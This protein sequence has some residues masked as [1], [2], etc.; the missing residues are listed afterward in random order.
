[1]RD[2]GLKRTASQEVPALLGWVVDWRVTA[3]LAMR[4]PGPEE[5]AAPEIRVLPMSGTD[6]LDWPWFAGGHLHD[7]LCDGLLWDY[8][9]SGQL[10][11][12]VPLLANH[13]GSV[14]WV[15]SPH[16]CNMAYIVVGGHLRAEEYWLPAG[17][18]VDQ[19]WLREG[20]PTPS[21]R[22]LLVLPGAMDLAQV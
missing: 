16:G 21:A 1:M 6:G 15:P 3:M 8:L 10:V 11:D 9:E 20:I 13:A 14:F 7:G 19:W 17:V 22:Q 4:S 12:M 18:Y 5:D 2:F